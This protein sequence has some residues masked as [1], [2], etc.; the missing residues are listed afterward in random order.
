MKKV[1]IELKSINTKESLDIQAFKFR[2]ALR[3]S[4]EINEKIDIEN[5][6]D[7]IFNDFCIGK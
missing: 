2:E 5:I 7:I 1:L 3:L 4:M 6:L